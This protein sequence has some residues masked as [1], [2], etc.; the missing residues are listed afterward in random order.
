M[1]ETV[2]DPTTS[3]PPDTASGAAASDDG[4]RARRGRSV[5]MLSVRNIGAVYVWIAIIVL[6]SILSSDFASWQTA[7]AIINQYSVTALVALSLVVPLSAAYYDL[8]IGFT[9]GLAGVLVAA[10]LAHTSMSPVLC[11]LITIVACAGVGLLNA[12]VVIGLGVDSFIATLGTGGILGAITLA[13]SDNQTV[14]GR[15]GGPFSD[16]AS[17]NVGGVT[18][19]VFYVLAVVAILGYWLERTR[20]GRYLY[21]TGFD[22]ESARLTGIPIA[23]IG[24]V[25]FLTSAIVA[26]FA[27]IV[28]AAR[29]S[30]GDPTAGPAYLIPAFSAAF[31]GATQLRGGRFNPYGTVIA[32]LLIGT[33]DTGLLLAGGPTWTAQ[34][35]DGLVLIAAVALTGLGQGTI[36]E[37]WRRAKAQ[38]QSA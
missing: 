4:P 15:V 1:P 31:L 25:A 13:V 37:R 9:F 32:V 33:G 27:G 19:P 7:K 2:T 12:F 16:L 6:F 21:A 5:H 28:V 17:T 36:R 35:F 14:I 20:M 8:S 10:L 29:V 18:L 23:R 26:G 38:R 3:A 24:V 30:A 34:L 11:A 22:R